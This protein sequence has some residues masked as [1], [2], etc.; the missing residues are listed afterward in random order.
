MQDHKINRYNMKSNLS[1]ADASAG[2]V[3]VS[4]PK[5]NESERAISALIETYRLGFLH[6]D[7][8]QLASIWDSQHDPLIY[9]AQE[10][11]EPIQGWTA[12]HRYYAALPEHLDVVLAKR[13]EDIKIDVLGDT[14]I[15]FFTT[16][17]NVKLKGHATK[18]DPTA[19][20]SM[21]FQQTSAGWR[22][23]HYHESAQSAQSKS[24]ILLS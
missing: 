16:H 5:D 3:M 19:R 21:I 12:I 15:A 2:S 10:M 20:V 14:A 23:I 18:Y 9:V 7:P 6:L 1:D 22:S 17:S 8:E 13:L 4:E 24:I 11:E